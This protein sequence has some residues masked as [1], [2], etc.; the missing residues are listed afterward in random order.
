MC[1][2]QNPLTVVGMLLSD[3]LAPVLTLMSPPWS[4]LS[5]TSAAGALLS[6]FSQFWSISNKL[7]IEAATSCWSSSLTNWKSKI[8]DY[9][10]PPK[11]SIHRSMASHRQML[12]QQIDADERLRANGATQL[13][14]AQHMQRPLAMCG[15]LLLGDETQPT[16]VARVLTDLVVW[17][18]IKARNKRSFDAE[19]RSPPTK[20][21][22]YFQ[23]QGI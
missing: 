17:K 4:I 21:L 20:K 10:K 7:C 19:F 9:K 6:S 23:N 13:R 18:E 1:I 3:K 16:D 14:R 15:Q 2:K 8:D 11:I 12:I 22:F 5:I